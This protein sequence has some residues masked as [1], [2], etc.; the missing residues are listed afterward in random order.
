MLNNP[1]LLGIDLFYYLLIGID[2]PNN[3]PTL[4]GVGVP[5]NPPVFVEL[6]DTNPG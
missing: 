3:P 2:A 1:E 5:N 4:L 6:L